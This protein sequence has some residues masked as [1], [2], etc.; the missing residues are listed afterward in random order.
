MRRERI[1]PIVVFFYDWL[2]RGSRSASPQSAL[3]KVIAYAVGQIDRAMRFIEHGL[4]APD[5]NAAENAIRPFVI[6]RKN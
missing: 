4:L 1:E 3:G 6:G 5:T 2:D